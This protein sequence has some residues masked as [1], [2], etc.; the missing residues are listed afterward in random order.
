MSEVQSML[1]KLLIRTFPPTIDAPTR[2]RTAF[3]LARKFGAKRLPGRQESAIVTWHYPKTAALLFDRVWVPLA[4]QAPDDIGFFA[5]S[6][7]EV[8]I[9]AMGFL[10]N[11]ALEM[12]NFDLELRARR[13][14]ASRANKAL[15]ASERNS[16]IAP[17]VE[18]ILQRSISEVLSKQ[19]KRHIPC[20]YDSEVALNAEYKHGKTELVLATLNNLHIV[21]E[22]KLDWTQ[23][24]NL[25]EDQESRQ[26]YRRFVHWLDKEMAGRP[27]DFIKEEILERLD[28]YAAALQ[29]HGIETK[30]GAL[31]VLIESK[32]LASTALAGAVGW[33]AAGGSMTAGVLT[34]GATAAAKVV[35]E[36]GKRKVALDDVRSGAKEIAFVHELKTKT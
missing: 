17:K 1:A 34:I 32:E 26:R 30:F 20:H 14:L 28:S 25:R 7:E 6:K 36:I 2:A 22:S 11:A 19:L 18:N 13:T 8:E 10:G 35:L 15:S 31:S 33:A 9:V 3:E 5:A 21:Q 12:G 27:V 29:K 24:R 23:V 16:T 4:N